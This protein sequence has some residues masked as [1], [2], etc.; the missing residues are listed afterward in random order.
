METY[1]VGGSKTDVVAISVKEVNG[2]ILLAEVVVSPL[3]AETVTGKGLV[4][5]KSVSK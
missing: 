5:F 4:L 2:S 1:D 3:R